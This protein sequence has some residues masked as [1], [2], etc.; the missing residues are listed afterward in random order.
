MTQRPVPGRR[1]SIPGPKAKAWVQRDQ[2]VLSPSYTRAYPLVVDSAR[3]V[4]V[5]DV[6]GH[7]FLDFTSGIAVTATGHCHPTVVSAIV[8]QA[9]RLIHM[10]G[11]DFYYPSE[12]RLSERLAQLSPGRLARKVFLTNSGTEATEAAMKLA[13]HFTRR[14]YYLAFLGAFHG[15]SMG[16]LSLSASKSVHRAGFAPFLPQVIHVPY[17]NPYRPPIGVAPK[18]IGQETLRQIQDEVF[19]RLVSPEEIAAIFVEPIQGE[20]GYILPP[21]TFLRD[22]SALARRYGILLVVDEIQTGMGRTGKMF[23]CEHFEVVPDILTVA[24]GIAS[25]LP[26]GAMIADARLMTWGPGAHG[27]TFGGNP[28]ACE[29]ALATLQLLETGLIENAKRVGERMLTRLRAMQPNHPLM[30]DVRGL[31]LMIGVELVS[32]RQSK[33]PAVAQRDQVIGRCFELGLLVLGCGESVIRFA[34]P[35]I[36]RPRDADRGLA[37]FE[38]ALSAVEKATL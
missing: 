32:D 8:S 5:I 35:L 36:L 18:D 37:L 6:D 17:P 25:G 26:L 30:G 4:T 22:L 28:I 3:G 21:Q 13:R 9:R 38:E 7:R 23:A 14:P 12:V 34:P 29:A 1:K 31:G 11:T 33:Q 19:H 15:R 16:A 20:G 10:S 2:E 27:N 24:K